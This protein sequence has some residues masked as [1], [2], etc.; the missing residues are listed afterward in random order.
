MG[1]A[2]QRVSPTTSRTQIGRICLYVR[3]GDVE[4]GGYAICRDAGF[5]RPVCGGGVPPAMRRGE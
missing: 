5:S 3:P 4:A 2:A 1:Y